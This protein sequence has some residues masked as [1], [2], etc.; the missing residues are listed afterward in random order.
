MSSTQGLGSSSNFQA[1][2]VRSKEGAN[3]KLI[4]ANEKRNHYF[5]LIFVFEFRD[6][7]KWKALPLLPGLCVKGEHAGSDARFLFL[8]HLQTSRKTI[9][10]NIKLQMMA[11]FRLYNHFYAYGKNHSL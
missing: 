4:K 7:R 6:H 10:T 1:V 3:L 9:I 11:E 2:R 5:L 8:F